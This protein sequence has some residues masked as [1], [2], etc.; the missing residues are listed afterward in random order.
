[1]FTPLFERLIDT[2]DART[3]VTE[4]CLE[5][6][7]VQLDEG[8]GIAD[9][10]FMSSFYAGCNDKNSDDWHSATLEFEVDGGFLVFAITLPDPW[11]VEI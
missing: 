1:M 2:E 9:V 5:I 10:R 7:S 8:D 11:R 6:E 3:T 4:G